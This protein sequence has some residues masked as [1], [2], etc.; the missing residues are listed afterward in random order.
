M[1]TLEGALIR[2]ITS[3]P[4]AEFFYRFIARLSFGVLG[5]DDFS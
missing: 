4:L 1:E 5:G 2:I 3:P